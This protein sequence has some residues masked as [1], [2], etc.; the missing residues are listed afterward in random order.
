MA[1]TDYNSLVAAIKTW[2]ARSQSPAFNAQIETFIAMA[3]QRMAD[4]AGADASDPIYCESLR[5]AELETTATLTTDANGEA[6]LPDD[7]GAL[8]SIVRDGDQLG[9]D[10]LTPH[11]FSR[12]LADGGPLPGYY[13]T[14]GR[15]LRLAP[16]W[17]GVLSVT[18][19][20]RPTPIAAGTPTSA[21]LTA[22]PLLYLEGCLYEAFAFMQAADLAAAHFARYRSILG[23]INGTSDGLRHGGGPLRMR[24]ARRGP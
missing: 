23:G 19:Y 7:A 17:E 18:Y 13:T 8:L 16:K 15:K 12:R 14:Q 9:L 21:L 6:M 10:Y 20:A 3:E 5:A 2:C 24:L 11:E 4:G 1:V 22:Y